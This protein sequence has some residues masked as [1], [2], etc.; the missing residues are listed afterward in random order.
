MLIKCCNSNKD[1]LNEAYQNYLTINKSVLDLIDIMISSY[2]TDSLNY[3]VI[4]N[5]NNNI[6]FDIP[7]DNLLLPEFSDCIN[8][9][10]LHYIFSPPT[11]IDLSQMTLENTIQSERISTCLLLKDGRLAVAEQNIKTSIRIMN[12]HTCETEQKIELSLNVVNNLSQDENQNLFLTSFP[13]LIHIFEYS[14]D[15]FFHKETFTINNE[16]SIK[17]VIPISNNRIACC[18]STPTVLILDNKAS[19]SKIADLSSKTGSVIL[20]KEL[21]KF[22]LLIAVSH[23]IPYISF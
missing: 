17:A 11:I 19:Y 2:S 7:K 15:S 5:L 4:T 18:F 13:N 23:M 21:R 1:K 20:L 14:N 16:K 12:L 22:N 3:F 6:G 9:F 8:F 10:N